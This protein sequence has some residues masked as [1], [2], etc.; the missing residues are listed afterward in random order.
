MNFKQITLQTE[1]QV[2]VVTLNRPEKLN[3]WTDIM[4]RELSDAMYACDEDD[5]VRAVVIT[6]AGRAFCAGADISGGDSAFAPRE[7]AKPNRPQMWPYMVRKPVIAA[8]NGAA[9]GV[10]M[11]YPMLADVRL[12]AE[13]A[14]IGFAMVRRGILPELASHLTVAEVAGFSNAADLLLTGRI[15][16]GPNAQAMGM[17]S[18]CLP[19]EDLLP[20][21]MAI[22]TDIAVNAAPVSVA[23]SKQLLWEGLAA[24]IPDMMRSEGKI[25]QWLGTSADMKEGVQSFLEK[26]PPS[27]Q[28]SVAKDIPD[29][30]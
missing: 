17:A 21:A 11:T 29:N 28:M 10:G 8:I 5:N 7:R 4:S 26:R 2:A 13:H 27:W 30:F 12:V 18:E 14:K 23:L 19:K 1:G 15:I 25:L 3:A 24:K 22:A 16:T 20:R 9:I 6:G